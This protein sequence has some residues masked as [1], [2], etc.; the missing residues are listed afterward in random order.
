MKAK[1]IKGKSVEELKS[2]LTKTI[3]ADFRPTLAIIFSSVSQDLKSICEVVDAEGIAIFG[4]TTNGEFIDEETEKGSV[5]A[6]LLEINKNY[7]EIYL[8]R[9][10]K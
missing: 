9:I 8:G 6:L 1:S 2:A 3:S 5:V 4:C 10:P 7:Y